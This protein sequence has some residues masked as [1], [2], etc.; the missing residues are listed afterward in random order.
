MLLVASQYQMMQKP[1]KMTETLAYGY[2]YEIAQQE[3]SW[4]NT[5]MTRF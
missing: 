4:M 3:L 5:N 2:L 1:E